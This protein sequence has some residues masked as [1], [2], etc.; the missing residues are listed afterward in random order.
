MVEDT[1]HRSGKGTCKGSSDEPDERESYTRCE[2]IDDETRSC[3]SC[4]SS[5]NGRWD[6]NPVRATVKR[7]LNVRCHGSTSDSRVDENGSTGIRAEIESS[8][9][10]VGTLR[11]ESAESDLVLK[12][13]HSFSLRVR[14]DNFL[15]LV[16]D[17]ILSTSVIEC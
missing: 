6:S 10:E 17:L 13:S 1:N 7:S 14:S 2:H 9:S 11:S 12:P 16:D 5:Q 3:D 15:R 8:T 4:S